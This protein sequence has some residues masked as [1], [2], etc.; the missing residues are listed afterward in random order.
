M[1]IQQR[2]TQPVEFTN[3]KTDDNFKQDESLNNDD[4]S[5]V[6]TSELLSL[7][8]NANVDP[9]FN[10]VYSYANFTPYENLK[11][12]HATMKGTDIKNNFIA[13]PFSS[14]QPS[15]SRTY[16]SDS[17]SANFD[18]ISDMLSDD[19]LTSNPD[20]FTRNKSKSRDLP[21][22][23]CSEYLGSPKPPLTFAKEYRKRKGKRP[24][25]VSC[26][27]TSSTSISNASSPGPKSSTRSSRVREMKTR[28]RSLEGHNKYRKSTTVSKSLTQPIQVDV[29]IDLTDKIAPNSPDGPPVCPEKPVS[30]HKNQYVSVS[31]KQ[32][33]METL[34]EIIGINLLLYV[35]YLIVMLFKDSLSEAMRGGNSIIQ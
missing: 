16:D 31:L 12:P 30:Q 2:R 19:E 13:V 14:S 8:E 9:D 17:D 6:I 7:S 5:S 10:E 28:L 18:L 24:T 26:V 11:T 20:T 27:S 32:S 21:H 1:K 4:K 34:S 3:V 15:M 33:I 22:T 35:L 29:P 23:F 25:V